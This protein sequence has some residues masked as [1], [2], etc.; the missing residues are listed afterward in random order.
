[1]N[2]Q[3]IKKQ[4]QAKSK[5]LMELYIEKNEITSKI[6]AGIKDIGL[7]EDQIKQYLLAD[8]LD[9]VKAREQYLE[10]M[11]VD[12]ENEEERAIINSTNNEILFPDP[13]IRMVGKR[14]KLGK[15][16]RM[17]EMSEDEFVSNLKTEAGIEKIKQLI[18]KKTK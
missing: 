6:N 5:S 12:M 9:N 3:D 4:I 16:Q 18:I 11:D 17:I 8:H 10:I 2:V 14:N 15:I 1:M 13:I 7:L